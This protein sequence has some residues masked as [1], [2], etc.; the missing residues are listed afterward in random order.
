MDYI[1]SDLHSKRGTINEEKKVTLKSELDLVRI[2]QH[3]MRLSFTH[4]CHDLCYYTPELLLE[5]SGFFNMG[6][7]AIGL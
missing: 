6:E 2:K 4:E 3:E 1:F 7:D 5:L